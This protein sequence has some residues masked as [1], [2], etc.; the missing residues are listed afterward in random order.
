MPLDQ[1]AD[2]TEV[3]LLDGCDGMLELNVESWQS[4]AGRANGDERTSRQYR[5]VL[6]MRSIGRSF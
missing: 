2:S 5:S 4:G 3:A 6:K 1:S